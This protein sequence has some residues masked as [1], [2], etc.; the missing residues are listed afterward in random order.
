MSGVAAWGVPDLHLAD[1]C[2]DADYRDGERDASAASRRR[3]RVYVRKTDVVLSAAER[4]FLQSGFAATSM[5]DIAEEA[6]VSKRTVYSNFGN[7]Q[8]LFAEVIRARCAM[9]PPDPQALTHAL[10]RSPDEGLVMLSV[11][12][13]T[14]IF[15]LAQVKLYQTVIAAV[16]RNP[17][18]ERIMYDGPIMQTQRMFE[19]LLA[20]HVESG[21]LIL[22]DVEVAAVRLIAMLKTNLQLKLLLG[23]PV[24]RDA[25]ILRRS[26]E[27][28][29]HVFLYGALPRT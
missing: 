5:D 14:N 29:V 21:L 13:L 12:F 1:Q 25:T 2:L 3:R 9:V 7:K 15:D 24:P 16:R 4:V 23:Q 19:A 28:S 27:A 20:A 8:N 22:D 18:V 10:E 26:A 17:D 11:D 6:G